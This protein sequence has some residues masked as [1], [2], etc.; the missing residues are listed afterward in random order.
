MYHYFY[1]SFLNEKKYQATLAKTESRLMDLG[2]NGKI[3]K[4]SILKDIDQIILNEVNQGVKT[5][6][7][8]G[9]DKTIGEVTNI[10]ADLDV[11]IG[12]IPIGDNNRI[13]RLL[14]IPE[15]DAACDVLSARIIE[16]MDLGYINGNYFFTS[17]E[18]DGESA[19]LNC[20]NN[21]FL[22]FDGKNNLITINNLSIADSTPIKSNEGL[23]SI[24]IRHTQKSFFKSQSTNSY[25]KAQ[26]INISSEGKS[27]PIFMNDERKVIK[28]PAEVLIIPQKIN[29]IVGKNRLI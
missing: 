8:V 29:M 11:T 26:K 16:K 5:V 4:L 27:I 25:L 2:I 14:G 28:T 1:D 3:S 19:N 12:I 17:L 18:F 21:Y 15:G 6:V 24:Q 10:I 22:S 13:A 7:I 9:N 20:D 23:F